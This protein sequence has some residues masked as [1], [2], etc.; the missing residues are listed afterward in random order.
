MHRYKDDPKVKNSKIRL[1]GLK[2]IEELNQVVNMINDTIEKEMQKEILRK[3]SQTGVKCR[4]GFAP[5][6]KCPKCQGEL[7]YEEGN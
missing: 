3:E 1:N 6:H 4:H 7:E 2:A 5:S